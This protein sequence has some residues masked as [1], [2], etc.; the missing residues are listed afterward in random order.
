MS[1]GFT[2]TNKAFTYTNIT[3]TL[4]NKGYTYTLW[5]G[6]ERFSVGF[7]YFCRL[8]LSYL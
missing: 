7:H 2:P 8:V 3:F 6:V 1:K 4:T 5:W